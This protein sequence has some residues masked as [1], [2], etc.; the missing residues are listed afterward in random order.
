MIFIVVGLLLPWRQNMSFTFY[1]N[2]KILETQPIHL[3]Q[4]EDN[5]TKLEIPL[6]ID[7]DNLYHCYI[8]QSYLMLMAW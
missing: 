5:V 8:Y 1:K 2:K 6:S 7:P 3:V 4:G